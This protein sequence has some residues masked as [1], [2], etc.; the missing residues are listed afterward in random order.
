MDPESTDGLIF[1]G[2]FMQYLN[3][4]WLIVEFMKELMRVGGKAYQGTGQFTTTS[5]ETFAKRAGELADAA[6]AEMKRGDKKNG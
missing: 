5:P 4:D 1:K 2:V 6:I 3:R